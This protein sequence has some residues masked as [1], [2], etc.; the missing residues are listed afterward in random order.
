M[1][2]D[3]ELELHESHKIHPSVPLYQ[4][5]PSRPEFMMTY[6]DEI[7]CEIICIILD[8]RKWDI[9]GFCCCC[10]GGEE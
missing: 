5:S 4:F 8:N 2:K 1:V 6:S 9:S 10:W 7:M 3:D